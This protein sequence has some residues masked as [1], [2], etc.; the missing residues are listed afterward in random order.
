MF[1]HFINRLKKNIF[2][3]L[4]NILIIGV[5]FIYKSNFLFN[6]IMMQT[7]EE[8]FKMT[9]IDSKVRLDTEPILE[10]NNQRFVLFPIKYHNVWEMYK[11]QLASFW[12]ADEIDLFQDLFDW[13]KLNDN[14]KHFIKYILAF[15]AAR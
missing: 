10:E 9:D 2:L 8:D 12:T 13:E 6:I 3:K 11:K 4:I 14:E 15:F 7:T 5:R 1:E